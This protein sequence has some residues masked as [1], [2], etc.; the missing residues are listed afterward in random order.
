MHEGVFG[1]LFKI[2]IVEL[3]DNVIVQ[4]ASFEKVN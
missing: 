3:G 4:G 1:R 2:E